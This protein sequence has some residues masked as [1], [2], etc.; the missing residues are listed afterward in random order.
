ME[1]VIVEWFK[2]DNDAEIPQYAHHG[3]AGFDLKAMEDILLYPGERKAVRTGLKVGIPHGYEMQIRPRSG[4]S[5]ISPILIANAP[6]TIDSGYRGEVKI[7]MFNTGSA[8]D[9]PWKIRKGDR[10]AQG[11]IAKLPEVVH[12]EVQTLTETT[13]GANGFGSTG[14]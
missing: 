8:G 7:I 13:R 3:D 6:G 9:E 11:V 4:M 2:I 1:K 5:L 14:L 10:I 12:V